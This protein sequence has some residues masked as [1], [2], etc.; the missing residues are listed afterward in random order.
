VDRDVAMVVHVCCKRLSL[1]F[2]LFLYMYIASVSDA[3]PM[4]FICLLLYYVASVAS[5][6]FKSRSGC[7]TYCNGVSTICFKYFIYFRCM[8]QMFYLDVTKVDQGVARRTRWLSLSLG[9]CRG[10][11]HVGFPVRGVGPCDG[12]RGVG[13][14]ADARVVQALEPRP[15]VQALGVPFSFWVYPD[16]SREHMVK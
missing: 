8:L 9:R 7:F 11:T 15:D 6:C 16:I 3:C 1:M 2:Y 13:R 4:C 14:D 12:C 10:S 5:G